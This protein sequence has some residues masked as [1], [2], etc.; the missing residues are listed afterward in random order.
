VLCLDRVDGFYHDFQA[1]WDVSLDVREGEIVALIGSNGAG[2]T[3][4]LRTIAGFLSPSKGSLGLDGI[5][6][7]QVPAHQRVDL[8][9]A[10]VPEGRRLFR[11]MTVLENLELGAYLGRARRTREETL[12]WVFQVFPILERRVKQVAG[13]LSGGEQQML[14]IARG[15]MSQ[16][17]LLLV[18]ELSL[19]LA[20][21][22]VERIYE[23][24]WEIN[25]S[26]GLTILFVE[27]NVN[28]ALQTAKRAYVLENG[29]VALE[30]AASDLLAN[31]QVRSAY[32]ALG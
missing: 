13:T 12:A 24:L 18:D 8:G 21:V 5:R 20:P 29:R 15:L 9:I 3:T 11:D 6:L 1:L 23:S 14:A 19:G 17:R 31:D 27:Q 28:L 16:P 10:L 26:R 22:A 32:L 7:D 30:G 4:V 2:K 25:A